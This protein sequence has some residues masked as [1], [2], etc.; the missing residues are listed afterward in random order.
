MTTQII[1]VST[2]Q[3]LTAVVEAMQCGMPTWLIGYFERRGGGSNCRAL[4]KVK[5]WYLPGGTEETLHSFSRDSQCASR[6]SKPAPPEHKS[7]NCSV[8]KKLTVAQLVEECSSH[9]TCG[10]HR[11]LLHFNVQTVSGENPVAGFPERD[12]ILDQLRDYQIRKEK[13]APCSCLVKLFTGGFVST[14]GQGCPAGESVRP[15][16]HRGTQDKH[17]QPGMLRVN[18]HVISRQ[19]T[20]VEIVVCLLKAREDS[21]C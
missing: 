8:R 5:L 14:C 16:Q 10:L 7:A 2:V 4:T 3:R 11:F 17:P 19:E 9:A 13:P 15:A 21:R 18:D 12:N 1:L 6:D 20:A